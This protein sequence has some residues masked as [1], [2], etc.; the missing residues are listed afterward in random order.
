MSKTRFIILAAPSGAGKSTL[1]NLLLKEFPTIRFSVSAT[2][3]NPREG[4]V[5]GEHYF[6]ISPEE[7]RAKIAEN[8]FIEW[9][10][11]Y[12][13]V[14]YGTLKEQVEKMS[15][16]G[17]FTLLDIDVFGAK[18]VKEEYGESVLSIFVKPPSLQALEQRLRSRGKDSE[19]SIAKRLKKASLEMEQASSFDHIIVNNELEVAYTQLHDIVN[20]FIK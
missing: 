7:F 14:Y 18:R 12:N 13:D 1:A 10:E 15:K 11:V 20:K 16:M 2:T 4:E 17:Y 9:E 19:E 6:F 5:N 8:A 3:R